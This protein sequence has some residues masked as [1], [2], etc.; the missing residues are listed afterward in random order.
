MVTSRHGSN[1][2]QWNMQ[3]TAPLLFFPCISLRD[4]DVYGRRGG[5]EVQED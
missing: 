3:I 2:K 4:R 5:Q 1:T